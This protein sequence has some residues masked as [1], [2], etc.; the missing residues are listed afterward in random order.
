MIV[1]AACLENHRTVFDTRAASGAAV[2]D[3]R[4]GTFL[5]FDLEISGGALYTFK[6]RIGNQFDV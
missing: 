6:I 5:D 3:N 1:L 2:F 4:A